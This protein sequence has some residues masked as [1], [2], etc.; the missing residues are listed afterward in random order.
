[1]KQIKHNTIWVTGAGTGIGRELVKLL[2]EQKN[3]VIVSGRRYEPL[4]SLKKE[5]PEQIEILQMDVSDDKAV[6][7]LTKKISGLTSFLDIVV[8]AA[9]SVA[10]EDELDFSPENY[11]PVFDANYFGMV[12]T[13]RIAKPLLDQSK[14]KAYIVGVSSMSMLLG[15]TRAEAYGASKAAA[16]YFLHSLYVDLPSHKYDVS[17][18]RPGFIDTPMTKANDF[19]MP[20]L[21]SVDDAAKRLLNG[22][23]KRQ[24]LII[25]PRRLYY[26]LRFL[27]IIP[28]LWYGPLGKSTSRH[29]SAEVQ[30]KEA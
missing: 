12:N 22:M 27:N 6:P 4:E 26:L 25:F 8:M 1:M 19:P 15:F 7:G 14:H 10:Y 13:L 28:G 3:R 17:I 29:N 11:R 20:F 16:D 5:Y 18:V 23:K 2:A 30:G 21:M 24:R 9:G